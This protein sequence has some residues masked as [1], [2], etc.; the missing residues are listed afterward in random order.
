MASDPTQATDIDPHTAALNAREAWHRR[1]AER[2]PEASRFDAQT[3]LGEALE[4]ACIGLA[5]NDQALLA[6]CMGEACALAVGGALAHRVEV[7]ELLLVEGP[8]GDLRA[9]VAPILASQWQQ[10]VAIAMACGEEGVLSDLAL[11]AAHPVLEPAANGGERYRAALA[12]TLLSAVYELPGL[13]ALMDGLAGLAATPAEHDTV[14][15]LRAL[16]APPGAP[17]PLKAE[18]FDAL[19]LAALARERRHA[20][21]VDGVLV[22][23]PACRFPTV[24]L[25]APPRAVRH[26]R[27]AEWFFQVRALPG[28]VTDL[29]DERPGH[30]RRLLGATDGR[31]RL[32]GEFVDAGSPGGVALPPALDPGEL[33]ILSDQLASQVAEQPP[34]Q[35]A[36]RERQR[37]LLADALGAVEV[38]LVLCDP[39]TG[40]VPEAAF[41]TLD[42]RAER[43]REPGRF[44]AERLAAVA[45]VYRR[46]LDDLGGGFRRAC[47]RGPRRSR[48]GRSPRAR[49]RPRLTSCASI[50]RRC[51]AF[52]RPLT[53]RA[54]WPSRC[55]PTRATLRRCFP[56]C[57]P[58]PSPRPT[59]TCGK[60]SRC[61]R[62]P[63]R[64]R[65]N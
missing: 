13:E 22:P 61:R 34:A 8:D 36:E 25:D 16:L 48:G 21:R 51:C 28:A 12:E 6:R 31:W 40:R 35:P 17:V 50:S 42:G 9:P 3:W 56:A 33:L 38:I 18:G 27:E 7:T 19:A 39:T 58:T 24:C 43:D 30:A 23:L 62:V 5:L 11:L 2:L 15:T 52:A 4:G 37:A 10:V 26:P 65:P 46:I 41:T 57:P 49:P 55:V 29:G 32:R 44:E 60:R 20:T 53:A 63:T 59:A 64:T 47:D 14:A 45:G 1:R 54:P